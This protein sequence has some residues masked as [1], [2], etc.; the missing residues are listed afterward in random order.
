VA[1]WLPTLL[2]GLGTALL[3]GVLRWGYKVDKHITMSALVNEKL[4]ERIEAHS[5]LDEARFEALSGQIARL[6]QGSYRHPKNA[7]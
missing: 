1:N 2:S 7:H 6:D 5:A 4:V 3:L